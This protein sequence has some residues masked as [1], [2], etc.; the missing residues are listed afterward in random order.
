M[1]GE[2]TEIGTVILAKTRFEKRC[3]QST[4][5]ENVLKIAFCVYYDVYY[6]VN[7]PNFVCTYRYFAFVIIEKTIIDLVKSKCFGRRYRNIMD[8]SL[9]MFMHDITKVD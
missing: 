2:R 7:A 3:I 8:S 1:N 4:I 6:G 9:Q 5:F